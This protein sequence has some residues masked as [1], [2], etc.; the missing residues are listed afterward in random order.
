MILVID[1]ASN[2]TLG[3]IIAKQIKEMLQLLATVHIHFITYLFTFNV[4]W[5]I[6]NNTK[7]ESLF[8]TFKDIF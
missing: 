1:V 6:Q 8:H 4:N 5:I 2:I 7:T 3:T